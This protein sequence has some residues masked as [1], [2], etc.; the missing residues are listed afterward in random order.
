MDRPSS[1]YS[2]CYGKWKSR[3]VSP[4]DECEELFEEP[5]NQDY[6]Q[7]DQSGAPSSSTSRS[8]IDMKSVGTQVRDWQS[9]STVELDNEVYF[10]LS[11]SRYPLT[12]VKDVWLKSNY[13]MREDYK[14]MG[15][16][17][18]GQAQRWSYTS[19]LRPA[20]I[21]GTTPRLA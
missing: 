3:R 15:A 8:C 14:Q 12:I 17:Y 4:V 19:G 7:S 18:D 2:I 10:R 20:G 11:N 1:S 16:T 6:R 21:Y 13:H 9:Y 5:M